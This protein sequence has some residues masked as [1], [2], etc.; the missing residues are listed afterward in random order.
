MSFQLRRGGVIGGASVGALALVTIGA[1]LAGAQ[2]TNPIFVS[3]GTGAPGTQITVSGEHCDG[4]AVSLLLTG[5][6]G[7]VDTDQATVGS[8]H[9]WSGSLTADE[10]LVDPGQ[11]L[12][13]TATCLG[14]SMIYQSGSFVVA[15][16]PPT[17]TSTS[18]TSTSTTTSTTSTTAPPSP[19]TT[20]PGPG[21]PDPTAPPTPTTTAPAP[22]T[23]AAPVPT[24]GPAEPVDDEPDYAG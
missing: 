20:R 3:P 1:G 16:V 10:E 8:D 5:D 9:S 4:T 14:G 24:P 22:P 15:G 19:T 17:T 2:V 18:T 12:T 23:T 21:G 7:T 11:T 13:I 6:G